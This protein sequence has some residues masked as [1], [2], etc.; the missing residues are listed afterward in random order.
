MSSPNHLTFNIEDTF[1]EYILVVSDYSPA[2][3]G[4]TYSSASN[5]STNVIPPT[6]S[7][8]SLF[9]NDP[10]VNVMNAYA[11]FTPSPIPIPPP[12]IKSPSDSPEFFLPKELLSPKKQKQDQYFQDYEMGENSHESTLEQ[13]EK[14]IKE[15]LNH[16]DELPLDPLETQTTTM[17]EADNSI[18][19]TRPREIPVAKRGNYKEFISYQPFNFNG[20]EGFVGLI[21]WFERTESV[22]SR[23]NCGEENKV[24]F[25]TGTLTDDALDVPYIT[26]DLAKSGVESATRGCQVFIAQV[27]EKKSDEKRLE[28]IPVVREFLDVFPEELPG[29][30][31][32]RQVE[33]QIDLIPG[34]A[35]VAR[36][37]YRLAPLEM[38]HLLHVLNQKELNIRQRRWL[39]LLTDYDCEIRYHPGKKHLRKRTCKLK[40]FVEWK[41]PL[42]SV[43]MELVVLRIEVGYHSLDL[44]KLYWWPN[45]KAIIA[46]YV[47]KCLTCSRVKTECQKPSSLLIQPKI[48][49]WKCK[50]I[51]MDFVTKLPRTLNRHDTIWVII[52]RLTKSAHFIP[53]R[54]TESMN[55]LT[56]LYIKEIISRHGVPISIILDR[57]RHFTSRFWQSLQIAL[58]NKLVK[59][60]T[61]AS[62]THTS[63]VKDS[64]EVIN[65]NCSLVSIDKVSE[66][67][68]KSKE[69]KPNESRKVCDNESLVLSDEFVLKNKES[70]KLE[71]LGICSC[72]IKM[73][74]TDGKKFD[75]NGFNDTQ[76]SGKCSDGMMDGEEDQRGHE[77]YEA[78][79]IDKV[80]EAAVGNK[81]DGEFVQVSEEIDLSDHCY[82]DIVKSF[83]VDHKNNQKSKAPCVVFIDEFY[84]VG[85]Q[86]GACLGCGNEVTEQTL[87]ELFPEINGLSGNT[88]VYVLNTT[89]RPDDVT[90]SSL[91]RPRSFSRY[92][93]VELTM[94]NWRKRKKQ[95]GTGDKRVV[96]DKIL[97]LILEAKDI[98]KGDGMLYAKWERVTGCARDQFKQMPNTPRSH[99]MLVTS[100]N[101]L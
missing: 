46:E 21:R 101:H 91:L 3:L 85:R 79:V 10:Y 29:L 36:A 48:P 64:S 55:T 32:V 59:G 8:F 60:W 2:S 73:N 72:R 30:R 95:S 58:A 84:S 87:Y 34:A 13:H 94:W 62:F 90:G 80:G 12:A 56:W 17:A 63:R 76:V 19:N 41:M 98:F 39:E 69:I 52:D 37:P 78:F 82:V 97:C 54:E 81:E 15:I 18:R 26:Q 7:N 45:M 20:T 43:L 16:L 65:K 93:S 23:S 92:L 5:N 66:K 86:R 89:N 40:I 61:K 27:M 57:D 38:Q 9:H 68:A 51:T 77:L 1:S 83:E 49:I 14:Q 100:L 67:D 42:K 53:T 24:A 99:T 35:P 33:F 50:R 88:D 25:A 6:S 4:K 31:P 96:Y 70:G 28:N 74:E 44:K 75:E 11:T 71:L 22:F 47:G